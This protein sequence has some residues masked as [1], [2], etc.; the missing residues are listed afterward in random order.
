MRSKV[1]GIAGLLLIAGA[2]LAQG[3]TIGDL[4]LKDLWAGDSV[5][6]EFLK[7]RTVLVE[8]WGYN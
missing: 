3:T 8:F 6:Q 7:D 5:D 2:S 4:E 1:I